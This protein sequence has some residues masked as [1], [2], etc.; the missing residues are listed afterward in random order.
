[1]KYIRLKDSKDEHD[2]EEEGI[3]S[4]D[5]YLIDGLLSFFT[6]VNSI[7]GKGKK[8]IKARGLNNILTNILQRK[9][10]FL[11]IQFLILMVILRGMSVEA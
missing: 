3:G 11:K 10:H 8:T 7:Y 1:M 4:Q 2:N 9:L 6:N 5:C